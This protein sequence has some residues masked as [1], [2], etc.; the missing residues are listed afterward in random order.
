MVWN[1]IMVI[2][3]P[4]FDLRMTWNGQNEKLII[5]LVSETENEQMFRYMMNVVDARALVLMIDLLLNNNQKQYAYQSSFFPD[6]IFAERL[7][8][9]IQFVQFFDGCP[10]LFRTCTE[11]LKL[12]MVVLNQMIEFASTISIREA[13][14]FIAQVYAQAISTMSNG[15]T[16]ISNEQC[17]QNLND[18]DRFI[19]LTN[20][21]SQIYK[22][23]QKSYKNLNRLAIS[24]VE[25]NFQK[26]LIVQAVIAMYL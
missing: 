24:L 5:W 7:F 15:D 16:S 12:G 13:E 8:N 2:K 26:T 9:V 25:S 4:S 14:E 19:H 21:L 22:L 23:K 10:R 6:E 18:N 1:E 20:I 17:L 11:D 3:L